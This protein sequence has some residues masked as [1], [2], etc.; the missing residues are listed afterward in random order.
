[1]NSNRNT[2]IIDLENTCCDEAC[3][4]KEKTIKGFIRFIIQCYCYQQYDNKYLESVNNNL[5]EDMFEIK[6]NIGMTNHIITD[7]ICENEYNNEICSR[8]FSILKDKINLNE[9]LMCSEIL[10]KYQINTD[11][12]NCMKLC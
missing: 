11:T 6:N 4:D 10:K 8:M 3:S 5:D 12:E 7:Y 1:M 9:N 2:I